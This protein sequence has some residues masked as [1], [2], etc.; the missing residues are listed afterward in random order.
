[1][2]AIAMTLA[3]IMSLVA[4]QVY[5]RY[6]I[7][8]VWL[9]VEDAVHDNPLTVA[10]LMTIRDEELVEVDNFYP[11]H[12]GRTY[13]VR[14]NSNHSMDTTCNERLTSREL[15]RPACYMLHQEKAERPCQ[16]TLLHLINVESSKPTPILFQLGAFVFEK[17]VSISTFER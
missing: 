8:N 4:L 12:V 1:M 16:N 3:A 15:S 17:P 10:D 7:I 14:Y 9:P 6:W 13:A 5:I 11:D 2:I